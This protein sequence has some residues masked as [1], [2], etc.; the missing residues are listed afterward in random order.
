MEENLS[1]VKGSIASVPSIHILPHVLCFWYGVFFL[2][3]QSR[4]LNQLR[5]HDEHVSR[6]AEKAQEEL[7]KALKQSQ[8][9]SEWVNTYVRRLKVQL[10]FNHINIFRL[11]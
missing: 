11:I 3:Q 7:A 6:Q 1:R 8:L 10:P 5:E 4:E 2:L 9:D